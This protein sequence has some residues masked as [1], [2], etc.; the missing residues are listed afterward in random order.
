MAG[1]Y[2]IIARG[3]TKKTLVEKADAARRD[4]RERKKATFGRRVGARLQ[5]GDTA[6]GQNELEKLVRRKKVVGKRHGQKCFEKKMFKPKP[7]QLHREGPGRKNG[8]SLLRQSK[9]GRYRLTKRRAFR[10]SEKKVTQKG[11]KPFRGHRV[12]V[13]GQQN[14]QKKKRFY[15]RVPR[16]RGCPCRNG[17]AVKKQI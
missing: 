11:K 1:Y 16:L 4:L 5:R 2:N 10:L 9:S 6:T 15:R 3:G 7:E 8:G 13:G 14:L 17:L 12:R